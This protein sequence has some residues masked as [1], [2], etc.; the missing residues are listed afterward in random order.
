MHFAKTKL[1][2]CTLRK[3]KKLSVQCLDC[4]ERGT[5]TSIWCAEV[6]P[7]AR[8]DV[9]QKPFRRRAPRSVSCRQG[10]TTACVNLL[11]DSLASVVS[12]AAM[13]TKGHVPLTQPSRREPS[14]RRPTPGRVDKTP[15]GDTAMSVFAV[16]IASS[17]P[18]TVIVAPLRPVSFNARVTS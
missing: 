6:T 13:T 8:G 10:Q 15:S 17:L 3:E 18:L 12:C 1:H 16:W 7:E 4:L 9:G 5:A 2:Q 14:L 11:D